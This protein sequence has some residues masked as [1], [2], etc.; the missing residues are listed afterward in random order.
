MTHAPTTISI[1]LWHA[2]VSIEEAMH[3]KLRGTPFAIADLGGVQPRIVDA[4]DAARSLG[5]RTR[6]TVAQAMER[7]PR[8][9]LRPQNTQRLDAFLKVYKRLGKRWG[10]VV[11]HAGAD[12]MLVTTSLTLLER[13]SL[14]LKIQAA[15][16]RELECQVTVGMGSTPT[17]AELA[18]RGLRQ[19]GWQYLA[20]QNAEILHHLPVRLLPRVGDRTAAAL[21]ASGIR[22]IADFAQQS[23]TAVLRALG[24]SGLQLYARARGEEVVP[25]PTAER[26]PSQLPF[27]TSWLFPNLATAG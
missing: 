19:P 25:E 11:R 26:A 21:Q 4:N 7:A 5:V 20:P 2:A 17:Y 6:M 15:C 8:L 13:T 3:P 23:P 27:P 22:T 1:Q 16:W 12:L 9:V 18:R 14:F 10:S 24:R